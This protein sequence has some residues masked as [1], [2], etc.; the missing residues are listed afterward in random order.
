MAKFGL[1]AT[2]LALVTAFLAV[3]TAPEAATWI[4]YQIHTRTGLPMFTNK[5]R[6]I[7]M[8]LTASSTIREFMNRPL[9]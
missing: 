2:V 9:Y 3:I 7:M 6:F 4:F 5:A 1:L 8:P